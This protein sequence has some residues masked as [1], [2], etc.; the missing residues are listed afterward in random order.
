MNLLSSIFSNIP[1]MILCLYI[2]GLFAISMYAKKLSQGGGSSAFLLAGR[3][4]TSPLVAVSVAGLAVGAAS[5]VG[6]AESAYNSGLA[7]GWYNGAWAA[8]ALVMGVVAA[9]KY[10]RLGISTLPELFDRVFG[11]ESR[12]ISAIS[13][14]IVLM[15]ITSLQYLAGGAILSTLLPEFFT[16]QTGM[17]VSAVVFIGIALI[18]GLWSSGLSNILSVALIYFGIIIATIMTVIKSGGIANLSAQLPAGDHWFSFQ[19]NLPMAALIGWFVVMITQ[20]LSAQGPVQIACSAKDTGAAKK[21]FIWGAAIIFPIGFLCAILGMAARVQFPDILPT[22]ALPQIILALP[23]VV[24]GIVL[25]ALWAA[26][27][28]TACTILMGASTLFTQD[29]F[30]RFLAPDTDEKGLL[31]VSRLSVAA[32]GIITLILAFHASDIVKTMMIGLSLTT[33]FT[34]IFLMVIFKPEWCRRSSA[35]WTT[36]VGL[37]GLA[38]WQFIPAIPLFFKTT[39]PFFNHPIYFEWFL[40]TAT[41]FSVPLFDKRRVSLHGSVE[42]NDEENSLEAPIIS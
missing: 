39:L 6:V 17:L 10:R 40:C 36:L 34:L 5:T 41:F 19:G 21:G 13:L 20:T 25:S 31:K 29:I 26:D 23:P 2:A 27:V 12:L 14:L 4:L 8:G 38:A 3:Q 28:S 15:M 24:A 30:K 1:F 37:A 7:A 42:A 32:I 9:G 16:F 18:G 35:F 11:K 22:L 33:A